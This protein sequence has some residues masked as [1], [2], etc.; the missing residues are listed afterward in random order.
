M[1]RDHSKKPPPRPFC[2][3]HNRL[4]VK[5]RDECKSGR[6]NKLYG[7]WECPDCM[8]EVRAKFRKAMSFNEQWRRSH[9]Q[10]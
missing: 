6:G 8:S 1:S 3:K 4:Y 9:G 5:M 2:T 10:A 7:V